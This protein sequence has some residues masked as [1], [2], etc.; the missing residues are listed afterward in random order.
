MSRTKV[1]RADLLVRQKRRQYWLKKEIRLSNNSSQIV[2]RNYSRL[3][4]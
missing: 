4:I 3:R 2:T 1:G